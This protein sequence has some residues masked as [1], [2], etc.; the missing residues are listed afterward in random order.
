MK[1]GHNIPNHHQQQQHRHCRQCRGQG[2]QA[3]A[4]FIDSISLCV[5]FALAA[6]AAAERTSLTLDEDSPE[7]AA[8]AAVVAAANT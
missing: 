8:A 4:P 2:K 6:Q 5:W 1:R 7:C 3:E